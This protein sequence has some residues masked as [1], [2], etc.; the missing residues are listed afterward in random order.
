MGIYQQLSKR[1]KNVPS[2]DIRYLE[3]PLHFLNG[4]RD[5]TITAVVQSCCVHIQTELCCLHG[6]AI[7]ELPIIFSKYKHKEIDQQPQ[8]ICPH[9]VEEK[10]E[11]LLSPRPQSHSVAKYKGMN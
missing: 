9:H 11:N 6:L 10:M 7:H 8:T 5:C 3:L 4:S 2:V 1:H